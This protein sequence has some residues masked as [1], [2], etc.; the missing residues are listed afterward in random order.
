[1]PVTTQVLSELLG[2]PH[3][4]WELVERVGAPLS[5][6]GTSEQGVAE[7]LGALLSYLHELIGRRRAHPEDD[8]L[9]R[10][11][12]HEEAKFTNNEVAMVAAGLLIAG[13]DSAASA[14]AYSTLA[15]L[16]HPD[17][18]KRLQADRTLLP[19][20]VEELVRY[21]A[22]GMGFSRLT[23]R[24]TEL[25]GQPIAVNEYVVLAMQAANRDPALYSDPDALDIGRKSGAHLAFG[26]GL[27]RCLGQQIA[28]MLLTLIIDTVLRRVPSFRL[29]VPL[30]E[31]EFKPDAVVRGPARLPVAWDGLLPRD[32]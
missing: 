7:S 16:E 26:H 9:S 19:N 28:R 2:V 23:T 5:V 13:H 22:N 1:M 11:L 4:G 25:G 14:I 31:I 17:Q 24:N 15:L 30:S 32:A 18:L 3:E 21:L 20:A 27:H 12:H 10:L 8:F 6:F 29:A